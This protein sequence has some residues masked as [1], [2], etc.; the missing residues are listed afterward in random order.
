MLGGVHGGTAR[1]ELEEHQGL[2]MGRDRQP[3]DQRG[4]SGVMALSDRHL[5][6]VYGIR[7][8]TGGQVYVTTPE[9]WRYT[10]GWAPIGICL[11]PLLVWAY[12]ARA[13]ID[14]HGSA[15]LFALSAFD[16]SVSAATR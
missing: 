6:E 2:P 4:Y 9:F 1:T 12:W 8:H 11:I 14:L 16:A 10:S 13:L 3:F 7:A 5:R 15:Q